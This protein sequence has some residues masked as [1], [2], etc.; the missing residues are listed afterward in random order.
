MY[1]PHEIELILKQHATQALSPQRAYHYE[2]M[3]L[4]VDNI[5]LKRCHILN[6][7]TLLPVPSDGEPHHD[8]A[9][10]L[11]HSSHLWEDLR[12]QPLE[13]LDQTLFTDGSLYYMNGK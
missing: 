9:K 3:I 13:N 1:V 2:L 6:P 4:N 10:V 5:T 7:A 11:F 8:C 12:D